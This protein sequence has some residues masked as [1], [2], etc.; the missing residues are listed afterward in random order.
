MRK[1]KLEWCGKIETS[2]LIVHAQEK[3]P[4]IVVINLGSLRASNKTLSSHTLTGYLQKV[5]L[6][7]GVYSHQGRIKKGKKTK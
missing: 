7:N 4:G 5:R 6:L 1:T 3:A 2:R